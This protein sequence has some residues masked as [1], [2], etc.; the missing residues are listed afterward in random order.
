M[1]RMV[2]ATGN[3]MRLKKDLMTAI[4]MITDVIVTIIIIIIAL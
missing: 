1:M 2:A 4:R 3:G